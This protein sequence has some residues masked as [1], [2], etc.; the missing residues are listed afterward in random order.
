MNIKF[1]DDARADLVKGID[2]LANAVKVTL[3]PKGRNVVIDSISGPKITKDGV[4]V[5]KA[6]VLEDANQN[7]G[8]EIVKEVAIKTC[9]DAGDGTTTATVLAQAIIKEGL[10]YLNDGIS[11]V[12][13]KREIDD[14]VKRV[15]EYIKQNYVLGI[16]DDPTFVSKV[17]TISAN[18]DAYIGNLIAD[19]FNMVTTN[20]VVNV[21]ESSSSNTYTT[22]T[23]GMQF[24]R[25]YLSPYFVTNTEKMECVMENCYII[26]YSG[27]VTN[28]NT[29]LPVVNKV[30]SS[31]NSVL[32][33]ADDFDNS[34]IQTV[35]L[36]CI[37]NQ[38]KICLIKTP[39]FGSTKTQ[40]TEDFALFVGARAGKYLEYSD[41]G[42]AKKV[43]VSKNKT[44]IIDG[45]H[46][47]VL[48]EERCKEISDELALNNSPKLQER[49][50]KLSG[51]VAVL[52]VGAA[53]EVEMK[54]KKDRVDD[55]LCATRAAIEEGI[56]P[57]GGYCYYKAKDILGDSIGDM[58]IKNA[59]CEPINAIIRNAGENPDSIL[60]NVDTL[61]Y[62]VNTGEYCDLVENGVI[63]PFK[64]T[65][66][67]L[68]NAASVAGLILTTECLVPKEPMSFT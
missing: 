11:P 44:V 3:G 33:A 1:G 42:F 13:I 68:E 48:L 67:A 41:I 14:A 36:N 56:V 57:G 38:A 5:A 54:E 23:K 43:I 21:A 52:Y 20:G 46:D 49:L 64:V 28:I 60:A 59:L 12:H 27:K 45:G 50:G 24:D 66:C 55:A 10:K 26:I 31:G 65:R 25:G 53:S 18:N 39:G 51:G 62:N 22:F 37:R 34:I 40:E 16:D 61:G 32:I 63:D 58:I 6:V 47:K 4:S 9:D 8:A 30:V 7:T 15:I 17:A 29:I 2:I 35:V 19:A